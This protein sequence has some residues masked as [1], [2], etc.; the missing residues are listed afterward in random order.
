MSARMANLHSGSANWWTS[1][2]GN[3]CGTMAAEKGQAT[4]VTRKGLAH[5]MCS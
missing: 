4:A 1:N 3:Y 5:V 2:I